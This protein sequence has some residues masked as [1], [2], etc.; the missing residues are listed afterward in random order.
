VLLQ[1]SGIVFP[2]ALVDDTDYTW[3]VRWFDSADQASPWS[4]TSTFSSGAPNSKLRGTTWLTSLVGQS[5]QFRNEFVAPANVQ[6]AVV[7]VSGV[8]Y[9]EL[10]INGKKVGTRLLDPGE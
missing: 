2:V 7:Y 10:R 9:Y 6:R 5:A 1:N 3:Q 8:G 4:A